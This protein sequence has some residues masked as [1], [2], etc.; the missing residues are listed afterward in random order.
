MIKQ[1]IG[2]FFA[3]GILFLAS[4][5][6]KPAPSLLPDIEPEESWQF[7]D[8]IYID[9]DL[10]STP[11][12]DLLAIYARQPSNLLQIRLDFLETPLEPNRNMFIDIGFQETSPE[13]GLPFKYFSK[14]NYRLTIQSGHDPVIQDQNNQSA[15]DLHSNIIWYTHLDYAVIEIRHSDPTPIPLLRSVSVQLLDQHMFPLGAPTPQVLKAS[16]PPSQ[17]AHLLLEF[18]DVMPGYTPAQTLRRWDGAHTG[19]FGQRHGLRYLLEAVEEYRLPVTLLDIKQ[20]DS[21]AALNYLGEREKILTLANENL[22]LMPDVAAGDPSAAVQG[23]WWSKK[24]GQNYEMP[25]QP[26]V[27]APLSA[28]PR[29]SYQAAFAVIPG[30]SHLVR[31]Q[32]LTLIP[33]PPSFSSPQVEEA[34]IER[35]GLTLAAKKRLAEAVLARDSQSMIVFGGSLPASAW[36]DAQSIRSAFEYIRAHPWIHVLTAENVLTHPVGREFTFQD[37][38]DLLCTPADFSVKPTAPNGSIKTSALSYSDLKNALRQQL[39][40]LPQNGMTAHAWQMFFKLTKPSELETA[41]QLQVNYLGQVGHLIAAIN[42]QR[43]PKPLH[44]CSIDLD[45]DG[46]AECILASD[47]LFATFETDGARLIILVSGGKAGDQQWIGPASQFSTGLS[48]PHDWRPLN[49]P[50]SD[51]NEIPG[52]FSDL[53]NTFQPFTTEI[54][55]N[56]VRLT[57]SGNDLQKTFSI[58]ANMLSIEIESIQPVTTRIPLLFAMQQR[59]LPDWTNCLESSPSSKSQTCPAAPQIQIKAESVLRSF[60]ADSRPWVGLPENPSFGYPAGHY[61]PFPVELLTIKDLEAF[62]IK[63]PFLS[64]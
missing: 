36:G 2:Y 5:A 59:Y 38:E 15:N 17:K 4:C 27:F 43:N 61:L 10:S 35:T 58:H 21:L 50:A 54:A 57:A 37:C 42:W 44:T 29:D 60:F 39:E 48:D 34:E 3:A 12:Q 25:E 19:P 1:R 13:R 53:E 11:D 18:W 9:S 63:A 16:P 55:E 64:P 26:Y 40:T 32:N 6:S 7:A 23:L 20:P 24:I 45:W 47:S 62:S 49:G 22:I 8:L 28:P 51:P 46:E 41:Q 30:S 33:L 31:W 56:Q 52:A 14:R